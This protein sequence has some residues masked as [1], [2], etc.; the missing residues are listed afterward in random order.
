MLRDSLGKF[1]QAV[2]TVRFRFFSDIIEKN[3]QNPRVLFS[4]IDVFLNPRL[5]V[6]GVIPMDLCENLL[7][8]F[9][10]RI[11]D[12]RRNIQHC[13]YEPM[14]IPVTHAVLSDFEPIS[15]FTL[16]DIVCKLKPTVSPQ[17]I[18]P[19]LLFRKVFELIGPGIVAIINSSL[20]T[21]CVPSY[22][23]HAT[24]QP[25]I[26]KPNLD[27][28]VLKNYWPISK[29]PFL[30]KILEKVVANQLTAVLENLE[31]YDKFQSGFRK[32]HSTE[33][34]LVRVYNDLQMASDAGLCSV[35]V[36]LD[37]SSA[38][39]TVDHHIMIRRLRE[40]VGIS[41]VALD[42]FTSYLS[43]RSFDVYIGDSHSASS[44]LFCGVP[45]GSVLG[46]ILFILYLLPLGPI[47]RNFNISYHLY[48]D[49]IQLHFTFRQNESSKLR[50]YRCHK[51]LDG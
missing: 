16:L 38:F 42:W 49:D 19:T 40:W 29:L 11:S 47:I 7:E 3:R 32:R 23:K 5:E 14:D 45:Q 34:A 43:D 33:T 22:F 46:P 20:A 18:V 12:I 25:I 28:T 21:G 17:D 50:L 6:P 4:T 24:I 31:L 48:A 44:P 51:Q 37:L 1:Q 15:L 26:K 10:G 13:S 2:K 8:F 35:L 27:P 30:S 39:D 41:G 9:V 36:L